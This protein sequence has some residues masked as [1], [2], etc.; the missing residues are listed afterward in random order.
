MSDDD[1]S[2]VSVET[3]EHEGYV[4]IAQALEL[5]MFTLP[6]LRALVSAGV[7]RTLRASKLKGAMVYCVEDLQRF[8]GA[9]RNSEPEQQGPVAAEFRAVID[10]FKAVTELA[11]KQTAQA[12]NHERLLIT[13]FSKPL[14]N[15]GESSKSLV[16][17]VLDQNKQLVERANAGDKSR[18][19]FVQGAETMLRDQRVEMR[20]Q[21]ELDRKSELRREMWEGVKKAAPHLLEGFRKTTG[22]DALEAAAK[23]KEKLSPD[24]VAAL[25]AFDLL[26]S[27]ELDLLCRAFGYDRAD[28]E[29]RAAEATA[30]KAET[31]PTTDPPADAPA[32]A[33]E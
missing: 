12:Q 14:E 9:P 32:E 21:L 23:L 25:I 1:E 18:L 17:A 4:P 27:E 5:S 30:V 28:L 31:E 19:E 7:V 16:G 3:G 8:D 15:L 24:K 13:A 22:S 29:R 20:E 10:G 6:Q 26:D 11:L 33:A 2:E